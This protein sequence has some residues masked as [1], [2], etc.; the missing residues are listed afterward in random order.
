ML[1]RGRN[2]GLRAMLVCAADVYV[3]NAEQVTESVE[4][5]RRHERTD[6]IAQVL[7]TVNVRQRR[8]YRNARLTNASLH[9][10]RL[11]RSRASSSSRKASLF[12]DFASPHAL[13]MRVPGFADFSF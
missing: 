7:Y 1:L 6:E 2:F 8:R 13:C 12:E 9:M 3:L 4:N 5:V 10:R 11:R